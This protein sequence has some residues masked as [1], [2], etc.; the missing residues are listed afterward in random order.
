MRTF[1]MAVMA[2]AAAGFFISHIEAAD[3]KKGEALFKDPN[4]AGGK[5][6]C[7]TCHPGGRGLKDAGAKKVFGIMGGTQNSLEEAVN[8][9]I[10]KAN[11]GKAIGLESE[12][13]K[14]I[15][16]Y[17]KSLGGRK[18]AP[19]YGGPGQGGPGYGPGYGGR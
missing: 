15:V 8:V 14:D 2:L 13:M 3:V 7:D 9:C 4:F 17:I 10:E 5:R 1:V 6:S 16:S 18:A 11:L 12:E 19:G